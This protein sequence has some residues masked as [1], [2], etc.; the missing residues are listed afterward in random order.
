MGGLL[1]ARLAFVRAHEVDALVMMAAPLWLPALAVRGARALA[2]LGWPRAVPKVGGSDVRDRAAKKAN[3]AY[4]EFPVP[5][6][7]QLI[8]LCEEVARTLPSITTP[9]LILHGRHDHTAPPACAGAIADKLGTREARLAWLEH[10]YYLLTLD[11]E[12]DR[13]AELVGDFVAERLLK[14]RAE[15][16]GGGRP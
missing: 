12:R 4:R 3:P 16:R 6:V 14:S 5:A 2:R 9:T 13:V 10:S 1:A 15:A 7:L 11:V 8:E